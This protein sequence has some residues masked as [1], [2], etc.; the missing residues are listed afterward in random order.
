MEE[1]QGRE[2]RETPGR[3]EAEGTHAGHSPCIHEVGSK[4]FCR[5]A[6]GVEYEDGL[7]LGQ[8]TGYQPTGDQ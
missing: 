2:Q 5:T 4:S 6:L 3:K 8:L 7:T 1:G